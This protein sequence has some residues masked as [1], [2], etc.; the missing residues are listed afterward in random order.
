MSDYSSLNNPDGNPCPKPKKK[1][2][3]II[4]SKR[5][6]SWVA[7]TVI[8]G[9][10]TIVTVISRLLDHWDEIW[11]KWGIVPATIL[12]ASYGVFEFCSLHRKWSLFYSTLSALG[13]LLILS[14]A[15]CL[16]YKF[17]SKPAF[18]VR[19][20]SLFWQ[21]PNSP[22]SQWIVEHGKA[23]PIYSAILVSF[24]NLKTIPI[25]INSYLVEQETTNGNWEQVNYQFMGMQEHT[26]FY[27]GDNPKFVREQE[28]ETFDSAMQSHN[29][30]PNETIR[31]WFFFTRPT[32]T[33][34]NYRFS[35]TDSTGLI[36]P[37]EKIISHSNPTVPSQSLLTKGLGTNTEDISVYLN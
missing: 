32:K 7:P 23:T 2:K 14:E 37:P 27:F 25:L 28:Y 3:K 19:Q 21:A 33:K 26:R 9:I 5:Q 17:A 4:P 15:S 24:V 18:C 11:V 20:D 29:I 12:T 35:F 34:N 10:G 30:G 6:L 31:G 1:K 36:Y 8:A 16:T 13:A 22:P